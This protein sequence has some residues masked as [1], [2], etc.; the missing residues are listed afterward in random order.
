MLKSRPMYTYHYY[1]LMNFIYL[2]PN[3]F[4]QR[5]WN[6][7]LPILFFP[8]VT[9]GLHSTVMAD[10]PGRPRGPGRP[11]ARPPGEADTRV[12]A[13]PEFSGAGRPRGDFK[14]L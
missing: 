5:L 1:D 7:L 4:G 2:Q 14:K 10:T 9:H 6:W 11:G 8:L 3:D 13:E 12:A